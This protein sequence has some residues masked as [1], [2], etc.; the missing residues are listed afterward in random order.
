MKMIILPLILAAVLGL[1]GCFITRIERPVAGLEPVELRQ[2]FFFAGLVGESVVDLASECPRGVASF[3][4]RFTFV[5]IV[6][7][8]ASVGIYTPR[9]VVIHCAV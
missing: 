2:H 5:D 6:L 3:G 1:S 7:A 9:T 4:D 8:I